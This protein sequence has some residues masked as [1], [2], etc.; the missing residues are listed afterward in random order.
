MGPLVTTCAKHSLLCNEG[1][2]VG[3]LRNQR[4]IYEIPVYQEGTLQG[5]YRTTRQP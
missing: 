1:R 4:A 3:T 5:I 2:V